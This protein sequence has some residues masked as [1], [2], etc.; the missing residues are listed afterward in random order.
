MKLDHTSTTSKYHWAIN[1]IE[2]SQYW[3]LTEEAGQKQSSI[4]PETYAHASLALLGVGGPLK[5]FLLVL[6]PCLRAHSGHILVSYFHYLFLRPLDLLKWRDAQQVKARGHD[7]SDS[8]DQHQTLGA[9][10]DVAG[11][12]EVRCLPRTIRMTSMTIK[13]VQKSDSSMLYATRSVVLRMHFKR[14]VR[15]WSGGRLT[16]P[17]R[18]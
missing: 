12:K 7:H 13:L 8:L 9:R 11:L 18:W 1:A 6:G 2:R 10:Q 14:K 15:M 3:D 5:R 17:E 4:F 16:L